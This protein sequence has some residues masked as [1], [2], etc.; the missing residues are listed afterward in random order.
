[1]VFYFFAWCLFLVG[2][3]LST[4]VSATLQHLSACRRSHSLTEAVYVALLSLFRVVGSCHILSPAFCF[5]LFIF[6]FFGF[7]EYSIRLR[8]YFFL[9]FSLSF[10]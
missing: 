7:P 2:K 4:L 6:Y 8:L 9:V 1:M 5:S 10:L 3:S